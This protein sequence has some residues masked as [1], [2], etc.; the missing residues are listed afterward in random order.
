MIK[1]EKTEFETR[2]PQSKKWYFKIF[3]IRR[4]FFF[5][6][7]ARLRIERLKLPESL[8]PS[9]VSA[10]KSGRLRVGRTRLLTFQK[11]NNVMLSERKNQ[12]IPASERS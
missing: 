4:E 3:R 9:K 11:H 10:F 12:N 8:N 2:K 6:K 5:A 1:I 7:T